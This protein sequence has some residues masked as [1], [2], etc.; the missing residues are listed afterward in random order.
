MKPTH[1]QRNDFLA[2]KPIPGVSFHHNDYVNVIGG[3]FAGDTGSIV[4]VEDLGE[5]SVYLVELESGKD[6]LVPA[7]CLQFQGDS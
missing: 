7:S 3:E 4:S 5:D 1:A 6:V 2:D